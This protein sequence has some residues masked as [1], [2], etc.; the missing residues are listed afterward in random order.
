[1][2]HRP[3]VAPV[4]VRRFDPEL[5]VDVVRGVGFRFVCVCGDRGRRRD[6]PAEARADGATHLAEQL[7]AAGAD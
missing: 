7:E 2:K 1:V 4:R 3:N 6:T 5:G